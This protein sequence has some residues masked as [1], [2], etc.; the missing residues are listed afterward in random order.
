[1]TPDTGGPLGYCEPLTSDFDDVKEVGVVVGRESKVRIGKNKKK[2]KPLVRVVSAG[3]G[4][5]V[6]TGGRNA[7]I[8]S[9][10][11]KDILPQQLMQEIDSALNK[12]RRIRK[13]KLNERQV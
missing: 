5:K 12:N 13:R 2:I 7:P 4:N 10:E 9:E 6:I 1:M 8:R 11:L 3:G